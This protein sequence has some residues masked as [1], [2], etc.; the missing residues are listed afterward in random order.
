MDKDSKHRGLFAPSLK[1]AAAVCALAALALVTGE[2]LFA[3][4][5]NAAVTSIST[6]DATP[7]RIEPSDYFP[8]Q[9]AAPTTDREEPVAPT[10]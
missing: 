1:I 3:K 8:S 5:H 4:H 7:A 9:F 10:F 2:P 6:A